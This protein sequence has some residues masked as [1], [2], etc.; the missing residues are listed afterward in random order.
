VVLLEQDIASAR[1]RD[2]IQSQVWMVLQAAGI[3]APKQP[4]PLL[5]RKRKPPPH[6]R[7]VKPQPEHGSSDSP[8][9]RPNPP[10]GD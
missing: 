5:P 9:E 1:V 7:V 6:L 8:L 10:R 3:V 2:F 4:L